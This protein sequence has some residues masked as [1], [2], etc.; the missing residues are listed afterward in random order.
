MKLSTAVLVAASASAPVA[1]LQG[2]GQQSTGYF[3]YCAT[4]CYRALGSNYL[5]C[6]FDGYVPGG[7][8]D[9]DS[10][11]ATP[12]CRAGNM[13]FLSSLA[14]C[15][16]THCS[17]DIGIIE[18]W[19]AAKSTGSGG[20]FEPPKWSYQEAL[21]NVTTAPTN[22]LTAKDNLTSAMLANET[23]YR[24]QYGTLFMVDREEF[25]H[26][27]Y[28]LV[29]LM[30]GFGIPL[31]ATWLGYLPF[32]SPLIHKL[33]PYIV[34]PSTIRSYQV[35][36]LPYLGGSAL[37]RGQALYV[38][39]MTILTV[40][41]MAVHYESYQP[42]LWY[43]GQ[44]VELM[45]YVVWR[46]GCY[47]LALL[48]VVLLFAARNN[49]LLWLTNWSHETYILL[50]RWVARIFALL[51]IIHSVLSIAYYVEDGNY[52]S[53]FSEAWWVWGTVG[54]V[55]VSAML[56]TATPWV[57]RY[58]YEFFLLSH[59]VLAVFVLAGTWY[60]LLYLYMNMSGYEQWLYVAFGVWGLDRLFRVLRVLK[61]GVQRAR[62]IDIGGDIV[63]V[64][65]E[66]IRWGFQPGKVV[67]AFFPT[68]QPLRPWE[69][70]PF[71]VLPT[72]ML[73]RSNAVAPALDKDSRSSLGSGTRNGVEKNVISQQIPTK[74]VA[75]AAEHQ[76]TAG[77]TFFIRKSRGFTKQLTAGT[78]ILALLDGPYPGNP[79]APILQCD[80]VLLICG[81]I[82][83]TAILPW[84]DSHPNVKLAWS[85]KEYASPLVD[86]VSKVLDRVVEK[87]VRIGH[88]LDIEELLAE[89]TQA[90]WKRIGV[91]ACGPDGMCD[92]TRALVTAAA[93]R[94]N[95][96][97]ELE[98]H[99]YSW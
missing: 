47:S 39:A 44:S 58:S 88:R 91:V 73:E 26:E 18:T 46:T 50:H 60:H 36:P 84:I 15:I 80:R 12:A 63:R 45:A 86:S 29:L 52:D 85:V 42:N 81:G 56:I 6:S 92:D 79:T 77:I 49:T 67:Y 1:A 32:V 37:T 75:T 48:P 27:K 30:M 22:V 19:W 90:G 24:N 20:A 43:P 35:R 57:R 53:N 74:Q 89:D 94:G 40:V 54:T 78:N 4:A 28:G 3:P 62:I 34:W 10:A 9:S 31:L 83:I 17:Y 71:S 61:N 16:S 11:S 70:H 76:P 21:M 69:N 64:D 33:K 99:A 65:I 82:G 41:F 8:M 72:A 13:P 98:V 97:F 95:A 96:Q 23:N 55:A 5:S 59:I 7:M 66:G 2:F 38:A 51:V 25:L 93:K 14:Y 68:L 87:D